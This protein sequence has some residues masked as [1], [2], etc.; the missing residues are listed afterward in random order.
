VVGIYGNE[1]WEWEGSTSQTTTQPGRA[2]IYMRSN[3][4]TASAA[5]SAGNFSDA[6]QFADAEKDKVFIESITSRKYHNQAATG[7][8][9]ALSA[10]L[11]RMAAYT[12]REV[13]WDELLASNQ[14][15]DSEIEGVDLSEFA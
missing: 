10:Q 1:P 6:L 4:S 8:E 9:S 2:N 13:T 5:R 3:D 14:T 15:Y 11:G 12:G 7:V